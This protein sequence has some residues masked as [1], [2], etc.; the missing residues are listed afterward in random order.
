MDKISVLMSVYNEKE[1]Y[2]RIAVE[3]ILNQTY[4]NIEF[5]I[6]ND[7]PENAVIKRVL[8]EY[9]H[10]DD[11]IR[12]VT[13][14]RNLGLDK[15]LNMGLMYATGMYIARMD[16]ND[17]SHPDRLE[18]E[19]RF[20]VENGYDFV[21]C[22]INSMDEEG[23]VIS[24]AKPFKY[25]EKLLHDTLSHFDCVAHAAWMTKKTVYD[26]LNGYRHIFAAEDYDFVLRALENHFSIGIIDEALFDCRVLSSGISGSRK[27]EQFFATRFLTKNMHNLSCFSDEQISSYVNKHITER[28]RARFEKCRSEF[29]YAAKSAFFGRVVHIIKAIFASRYSILLLR[30]IMLERKFKRISIQT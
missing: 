1:E 24:Y 18:K 11:R 17:Y 15:S 12:V 2:L 14:D 13:N 4:P 26:S 19:L 21:S 29:R 27:M 30:R 5:I 8:H 7:D 9:S 16:S 25:T 23:H 20:M 28:S 3:S 10:K 22:F 6:V